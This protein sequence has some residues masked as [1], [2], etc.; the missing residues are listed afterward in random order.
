MS[1]LDVQYGMEPRFMIK[2]NYFTAHNQ[3]SYATTVDMSN[4]LISYLLKDVKLKVANTIVALGRVCT[5]N[6]Q[7]CGWTLCTKLHTVS[8]NI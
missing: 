2:R 7:S 5:K 6:Y 3:H 8:S 1:A 4:I